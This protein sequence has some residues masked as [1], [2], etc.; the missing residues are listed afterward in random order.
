MVCE[1]QDYFLFGRLS[2]ILIQVVSTPL[3]DFGGNTMPEENRAIGPGPEARAPVP[4]TWLAFAGMRDP[5]MGMRSGFTPPMVKHRQ[6]QGLE[7]GWF[8]LLTTFEDASKSSTSSPTY[9][10]ASRFHI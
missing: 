1:F 9:F 3:E 10:V 5:S 2:P 4:K 6:S 7:G 8:H